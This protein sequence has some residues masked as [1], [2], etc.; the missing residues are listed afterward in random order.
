LLQQPKQVTEKA[1]NLESD[2]QRAT[3]QKEEIF[4]FFWV[5]ARMYILHVKT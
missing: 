4:C 3:T 1:I 2:K 5:V